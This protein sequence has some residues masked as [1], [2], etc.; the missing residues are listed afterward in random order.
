MQNNNFLE[1]KR[2]DIVTSI[3]KY[4]IRKINIK[5]SNPYWNRQIR[6][7]SHWE[8]VE[9]EVCYFLTIYWSDFQDIKALRLALE[10]NDY[11][12]LMSNENMIKL[13]NFTLDPQ[14]GE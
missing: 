4:D 2:N 10:I 13:I 6:E 9:I 1:C 3:S 7:E 11:D 12:L 5:W 14:V 8:I